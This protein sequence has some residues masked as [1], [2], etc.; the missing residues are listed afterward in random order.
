MLQSQAL[1]FP[2]THFVLW[3]QVIHLCL[4]GIAIKTCPEFFRKAQVKA[5]W[6]N[7]G[8]N[9][10]LKPLSSNDTGLIK[11]APDVDTYLTISHSYQMQLGSISAKQ[12]EK[13]VLEGHLRHIGHSGFKGFKSRTRKSYERRENNC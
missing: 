8:W 12:R 2:W 1:L 5:L 10:A 4:R 7:A 11:V 9:T 6:Q 13:E 3:A